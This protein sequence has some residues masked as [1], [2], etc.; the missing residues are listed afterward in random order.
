MDALEIERAHLVGNSMGGRVA[1]EVGL[2]EP[3][4]VGGLALLCPAVAFVRRSYAPIVRL[5]RPELG[6]LPHSL[7][8]GRIEGQFWSMFADRDLVDPSVADIVVDEFERIYRSAGARLAFLASARSIYLEPPF[9]R[10]GLFP[11]LEALEPPAMFVWGSHDRLIPPRF[12]RHVER[13]LPR[14]RAGRP[15]GLRPRAA[16]RA[17]GAHE[18]PA[19]RASSR[20]STRWERRCRCGS[21]PR[22]LSPMAATADLVQG[23]AALVKSRVPAAD[24]DERDPDYIRET[25]PRLWL[26]ASLWFRGEVRGLGN[27]PEE[28][29][30]L[31][32]GNHS[33]GNLTPDTGVFTLAFS[34]YFGVER[35]FHQLAHNLVLSHARAVVPAQVRDRRRLARQRPQGARGRRRRARLPRRRLRGPP[36]ELGAQPR[37][38]RRPQGLHPARARRRTCRSCRSSSIGGQETSLFLSRGERLAKGAAARQAVPPEGAADLDR[39]ALGSSTSATCSATSRCRP[40]SPSRRCRRSTCGDEFGADPDVDEVYDHVVRLMQETLDALAAERR[41]PVIG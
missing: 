13:W 26:L 23:V 21:P 2:C 1:L 32:V 22:L 35:A 19:R 41:F 28:G 5:L 36:P 30:V 27:V 17:P 12:S 34:T 4:R 31:L 10:G 8:R 18:R 37:R 11:R 29:P 38:L 24:L 33:G 40:R 6:L 39:P 7:G 16:G 20:A 9:G 3:G 14:R 15:R 25:L